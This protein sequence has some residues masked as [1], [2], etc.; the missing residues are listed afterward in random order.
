MFL[1]KNIERGI[2]KTVFEANDGIPYTR[3]AFSGNIQLSIN[4]K[5]Y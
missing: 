1:E 3:T 5:E 4:K 2:K